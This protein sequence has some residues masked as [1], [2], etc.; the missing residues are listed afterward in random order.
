M[1][2]CTSFLDYSGKVLHSSVG[3]LRLSL[4]RIKIDLTGSKFD[5]TSFV[6]KEWWPW[7][8]PLHGTW[9]SSLYFALSE[10]IPVLLSLLLQSIVRIWRRIWSVTRPVTISACWCLCVRYAKTK[11]SSWPTAHHAAQWSF[12]TNLNKVVLHWEFEMQTRAAYWSLE[13]HS[14]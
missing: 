10:I 2:Q 11:E 6:A 13:P 7:N 1:F 12:D 5:N 9:S 3:L 14:E 4:A 8:A